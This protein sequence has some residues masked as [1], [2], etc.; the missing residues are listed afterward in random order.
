MTKEMRQ[1]F[2][3]ERCSEM[4]LLSLE[5]RQLKEDMTQVCQIMQESGKTNFLFL[6]LIML[7]ELEASSQNEEQGEWG[8]IQESLLY[9]MLN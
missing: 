4:G 5:W 8:R 7:E 1:I 9:M 2:F 3:G 6:F